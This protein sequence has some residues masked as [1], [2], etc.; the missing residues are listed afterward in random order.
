MQI[1]TTPTYDWL[2]E[3]ARACNSRLLIGSPFVN[4]GI[5][6]LTD[7]VPKGASRTLVTRTDLR[8]FAMGA[9]SLDTLCSLSKD[10]VSIRS[11]SR[12]HAKMYVFDSSV[13]LVTSANATRAGMWRNFECGLGIT[14]SHT[15]IMLAKSLLN[16]FGTKDAVDEVGLKELLGMYRH[17]ESIKVTVAPHPKP[18]DH[19]PP[20]PEPTFS[21]SD[22]EAFLKGFTGWRKLTLEGVLEMSEDGFQMDQLM[23]VCG[24][25]AARKYP[26]NRF[27]PEKLRQ[28]LQVLRNR[29]LVEFVSPGI[30]R[31]TMD[32][33]DP[34]PDT[35]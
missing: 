21:I 13:A 27:V 3:Q 5:L 4:D 32:A 30:Y 1:I 9:S 14:D 22:K 35:P 28:Q 18:D 15:I 7:L 12:L 34:S 8:D 20:A 6:Q 29:G 23:Q 24:P 26:K 11:L 10:G 2:A 19:A 31:R 16:G 17:L 33:V 25:Q